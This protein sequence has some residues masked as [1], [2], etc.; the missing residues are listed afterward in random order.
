MEFNKDEI[1]Q[2]RFQQKDGT[3]IYEDCHRFNTIIFNHEKE[4]EG[5]HVFI[6]KEESEL[7]TSGIFIWKLAVIEANN[8]R[9]YKKLIKGLGEVG[10]QTVVADYMT[11]GDRESFNTF[12]GRYPN[13]ENNLIIP[14]EHID[15]PLTAPQENRVQFLG[16]LLTYNMI[17]PDSFNREVGL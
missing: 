11:E 4:W 17:N 3:M 16:H 7:I 9:T 10:C 2:V 1:Y 8:L 15:V 14:A 5:D 6:I 12:F 13:Q